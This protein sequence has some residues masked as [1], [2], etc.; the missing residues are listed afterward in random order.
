MSGEKKVLVTGASGFIGHCLI[1]TLLE[2]GYVA[3]AGVR[4]GSNTHELKQMGAILVRLDMDHPEVLREELRQFREETG[5]WDY[6]VHTAGVTKCRDK[7]DFDRVNYFNT[8][9]FLELLRKEGMIPRKFIF[10]SSLSVFGPIHEKDG[11]PISEKDEAQPNTAYGRSKLRAEQ[12]LESLHDVPSVILRPT[13]VYGPREKD[14]FMM[15][16][17]IKR[18]FDFSVGFR[19]QILTFIYVKDVAQAV[20]RSMESGVVNRSYFLSDGAEY[21]S[22]DFSDLIQKELGVKGIC[23]LC[24][25]LWVLKAISSA[26]QFFASLLGR[27][28][29]LNLDKYKIM[30]QRNWRC[31]TTPAHE[32]LGYVP[33]YDLSRGVKETINWYKKEKWL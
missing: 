3:Y 11:L 10:L 26:A 33:Q 27:S 2:Q 1:E 5:S 20:L 23:R 32:E 15:A 18:H 21:S 8:R 24:V 14:Y 19:P 16:G 31:D 4:N 22:R 7:G 28:S 29:T 25:P 9:T 12:Y 17:S 13:G 30:K 6:I